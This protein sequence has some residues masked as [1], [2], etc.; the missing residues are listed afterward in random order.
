[1][2][3]QSKVRI[4]Q[5]TTVI[6]VIFGLVGLSYNVWRM[7]ITETNNNTRMAC[8]ELLTELSELEQLVYAAHYDHDERMGS[9]RNGWVKVGLIVDLSVLTSQPV[10][11]RAA[12]LKAV[13]SDNWQA[14]AENME[15]TDRIVSAIDETRKEIKVVLKNLQ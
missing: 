6:G 5:I 1:M 10:E 4:Y 12:S 13:W 15:A 11:H 14:Y 9:P 8:F 2:E 3:L 7:E